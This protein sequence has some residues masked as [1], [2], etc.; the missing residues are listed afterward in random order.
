MERKKKRQ[1]KR[2]CNRSMTWKDFNSSTEEERTKAF[3]YLMCLKE[4]R[5]ERIK[6]RGCDDGRPR[7]EYTEKINTSSPPASLVAIMLTCKYD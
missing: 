5:D 6:G 2:N 3:K 4:K 1:L 7:Q